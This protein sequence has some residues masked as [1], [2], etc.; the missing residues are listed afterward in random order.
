MPQNSEYLECKIGRDGEVGLTYPI[1]VG[2]MSSSSSITK[3]L[4]LAQNVNILHVD[5]Y[6][7][8]H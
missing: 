4:K 5:M 3:I 1:L 8:F 6:T 2:H 7:I